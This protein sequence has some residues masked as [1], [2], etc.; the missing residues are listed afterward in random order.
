[1]KRML[2]AAAAA[3]LASGVAA[4]EWPAKRVITSKNR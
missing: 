1:M 2:I 3:L 4:A